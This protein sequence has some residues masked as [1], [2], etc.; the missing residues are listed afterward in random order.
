[1]TKA[2]ILRVI[3]PIITF[4]LGTI[5]SIFTSRKQRK[6]NNRAFPHVEEVVYELDLSD[7]NLKETSK[8]YMC[9]D[10]ADI[11]QDLS[12][13]KSTKIMYIQVTNLGPGHML[14]C[15]VNVEAVNEDNSKRWPF[16]FHIPYIK[17]DEMILVPIIHRGMKEIRA[18]IDVINIKYQTLDRENMEYAFQTT[19]INQSDTNIKETLHY[20]S[21]FIRK[22]IYK[23][24]GR[25]SLSLFVRPK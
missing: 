18:F 16:S 4:F 19:K 24:K 7:N 5:Y 20:K 22:N 8:L 15:N 23:F 2:E 25:K 1:M 3:V 17:K 6:V 21:W 13:D 14:N 9:G 10:Y 12:I 11:M